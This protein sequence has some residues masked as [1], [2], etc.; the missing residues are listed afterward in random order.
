[1]L[2]PDAPMTDDPADL[3]P[4]VLS[5]LMRDIALPNGLGAVGY[6]DADVDDLVTGTMKQQ[7]L[8]SA[9]PKEVTEDDA[10]RVFRGSF[11]IW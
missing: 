9:C 11:E 2:D 10:A 1:M 7:R 5:R 6:S 4:T 3:L 8:L